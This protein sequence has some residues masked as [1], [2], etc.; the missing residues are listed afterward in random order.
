[1]WH[2]R[3]LWEYMITVSWPLI[4]EMEAVTVHYFVQCRKNCVQLSTL[5]CLCLSNLFKINSS[6]SLGSTERLL[7][8]FIR[9][10]SCWHWNTAPRKLLRHFLSL[11]TVFLLDTASLPP[12]G[13]HFKDKNKDTYLPL[14]CIHCLRWLSLVQN[15]QFCTS[16]SPKPE[17]SLLSNLDGYNFFFLC[18][19]SLLQSVT[20][21]TTTLICQ[22]QTA[23]L[24]GVTP[25]SSK[26]SAKP[27][28]SNNYWCL[29][30]IF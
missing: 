19:P 8:S 27:H 29:W 20:K 12:R 30:S 14:P 18:M 4:C 6:K 11:V 10:R 9:F 1:M 22:Y 25:L 26:V 23:P 28:P 21:R 5:G 3:M 16:V 15:Q 2:F 17:H 13:W 7:V 24:A